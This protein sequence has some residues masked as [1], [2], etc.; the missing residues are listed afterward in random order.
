MFLVVQFSLS[1]PQM[2]YGSQLWPLSIATGAGT[3]C[4]LPVLSGVIS[5]VTAAAAG[6]MQV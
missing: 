4:P 2:K 6:Y 1:G 3:V 5:S